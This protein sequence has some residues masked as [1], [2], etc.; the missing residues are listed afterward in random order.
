MLDFSFTSGNELARRLPAEQRREAESS[1]AR[2]LELTSLCSQTAILLLEWQMS[3]K[4]SKRTGI[5]ANARDKTSRFAML[6]LF[7]QLARSAVELLAAIAKYL[8]V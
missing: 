1:K 5:V 3:K 8:S 4:S 2:E 6:K 7:L